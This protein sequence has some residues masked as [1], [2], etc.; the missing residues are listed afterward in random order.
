MF[1]HL[2]LIYAILQAA[3]FL[4]EVKSNGLFRKKVFSARDKEEENLV[5]Q[6]QSKKIDTS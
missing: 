6:G 1:S 2:K 4:K 3:C 5:A